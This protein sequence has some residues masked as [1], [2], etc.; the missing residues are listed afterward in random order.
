[1]KSYKVLFISF[2]L[3]FAVSIHT[4]AQKKKPAKKP[5]QKTQTQKKTTT[6]SKT[7]QPV[8]KKTPPPTSIAEGEKRVRDIVDF[9]Q[10]MLNTLG[11][12]TTLS[13]DK[14]VLVKES[15]SKIFR[16]EKVQVEDDLDDQRIVVTNKDIVPYLKDVDFFFNEAKF[17]F[18]IEDIKSSTMPDGG[19]FY[20][21]SARRMFTGTTTEGNTISNTIPRY[22]EINYD[23]ADQDLRIVSIYTHEINEKAVLT[24]WWYDLSA[25]WRAILLKKLPIINA[26]D[27]LLPSD[28]KKITAIEDLDLSNNSFIQNLEPLDRLSKLKFLDL[29]G[30]NITSIT[31]LRNLTE[32]ETLDLSH[33]KITD[34][35]PLKYASKM[36][37]LDISYTQVSDIAVVEKMPGLQNLFMHKTPVT[38]ILPVSFLTVLQEADLGATDITN[39]TPL[40]SLMNITSLDIS[41][42]EVQDLQPIKNLKKISVLNIDSTRVTS[43]QVLA[44]LESL[45]T[46]YA[47]HTPVADLKPLQK[48]PNIEMIYADHS[49]VNQTTANNFM[50]ANKARVIYD[51]DNIKAWWDTLPSE[52]KNVFIVSAGVGEI[53][54]KE[55]FSKISLIDSINASG[56]SINSLEPLRKLLKLQVVIVSNTSVSDLS[57]LHDRNEIRYLDI[58]STEVSDISVA[59]TLPKLNILRADKSKV[60]NIERHALPALKIFYA[61]ETAVHDITA[62]EF[63]E[64]NTGCLLVYKTI[65]I[66]RWWQNLPE[67]W[68]TVFKNL[69]KADTTRENFHRL[70]ET[71]S[72]QFKDVPV[73]D[74]AALSEFV[75]LKELHFSGTAITTI[76]PLE[77]I[78]SLRSL[79]ATS[80]PLQNIEAI[81]K[82]TALQDLNLSNTP[83]EDLKSIG[84]LKELRKLNCSGTQIRRLDPIANLIFLEHLDCSNT[85]V[86]RLDPLNNLEL[87]TFT[88]YN[89]KVSSRAIE[90]FKSKHPECQVV[91]YR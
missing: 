16:D 60:E 23:Q 67:S 1:M 69:L 25:E 7:T 85:N 91:Y 51:S 42:T 47:N 20:K 3:V 18:S 55:D 53:P 5:A 9:L 62:R 59:A 78:A 24:N 82:L 68:K 32:L 2:V 75:R 89:T 56:R 44:G 71:E 74:L 26:S 64:K 22:I 11:S 86:S 12:S 29:S 52:W 76:P 45:K 65:H 31:P 13:R 49:G 79:H 66:K 72:L 88:C 10:Y 54:S 15:Y 27:S 6:T 28:I 19:L 80:S 33:T 58:S 40:E 4:E 81:G 83:L 77:N 70:V 34:L 73:S 37:S 8:Q 43:L 48:L 14:E 87:K 63:L 46:L 36:V 17:E 39:L 61:D 38:N 57:P 41:G 50:A 90:N 21:V 30:T 35:S 84:T